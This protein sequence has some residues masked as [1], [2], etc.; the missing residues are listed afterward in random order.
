MCLIYLTLL[1]VGL[2]LLGI[3]YM[4]SFGVHGNVFRFHWNEWELGLDHC[5]PVLLRTAD[6][7][8]GAYR[9]QGA[10]NEMMVKSSRRRC[11]YCSL[12]NSLPR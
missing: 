9:T 2:V 12:A 4:Y 11:P 1:V 3:W 10:I 8:P 6:Q 7:E 5:D